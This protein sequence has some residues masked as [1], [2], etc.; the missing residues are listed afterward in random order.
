MENILRLF[1]RCQGV[2]VDE[3]C[4]VD[5]ELTNSDLWVWRFE[6]RRSPFVER[7]VFEQYLV[8]FIGEQ[9][10]ASLFFVQH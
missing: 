4:D 5:G 10:K 9:D 3:T 1:G 2:A 8:S 7:C 6:I